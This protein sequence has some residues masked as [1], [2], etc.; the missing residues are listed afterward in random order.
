M[1]EQLW[2]GGP[3]L[4]QA[5]GVFP[6]GTDAL[7]LAAFTRPG[8]RDRVLDLGTGSGVLPLVLC[9]NRPEIRV[10]ALDSCPAACTLARTNMKRNRI[11][12]QVD[13]IEGDLRQFRDCLPHGAFDLAVSNPP[14]FP[15]DAGAAASKGLRDAR[16][17]GTCT[18]PE[19]CAAAAWALRYGGRFCLVFRPERLCDLLSALREYRLEPKR[20]Q[21]VHHSP[22]MPVNL[23]LVEARYGGKP[24]LVWEKDRYL[25]RADGSSIPLFPDS[26]S[27]DTEVH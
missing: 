24:G 19:L 10:T 11:I 18:L 20:L 17:D 21:T 27:L 16:S 23:V 8:N 5:E 2:P 1:G 26:L 7:L 14:Y 25:H 13:V 12:Q 6:L 9:Q 22:G 3:V 15:A 4:E